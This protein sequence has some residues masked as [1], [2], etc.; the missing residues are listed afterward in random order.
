MGDEEEEGGLKPRKTAIDDEF[1]QHPHSGALIRNPLRDKSRSQPI[2]FSAAEYQHNSLDETLNE[3]HCV[4][5]TEASFR[6]MMSG[7]VESKGS[8]MPARWSRNF[9]QR[10]ALGK[11][12]H[13]PTGYEFAVNLRKSQY[14][15][16]RHARR[17]RP[18]KEQSVGTAID[19][20]NIEVSDVDGTKL[21]VENITEGLVL[22]WNRTHPSFPVKVGD[23]ITRVNDRR[24]NSGLMMEEMNAA[25][26]VLR[27]QVQ[28]APPERRSSMERQ[29]SESGDVGDATMLP[30]MSA[31]FSAASLAN[32]DKKGAQ[33]RKRPPVGE[34]H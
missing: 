25:L 23:Y 11:I 22:A 33:N 27:L 6:D 1:F 30:E 32:P 31:D 34:T 16:P 18:G 20:L 3:W 2:L 19:K 29:A 9:S 28:R 26:D 8:T 14:V 15:Q 13:S 5:V 21:K 12:H 24:L 4:N 17:A 7:F 10:V